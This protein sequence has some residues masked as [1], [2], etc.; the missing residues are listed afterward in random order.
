MIAGVR[1]PALSCQRLQAVQ[2]GV[3]AGAVPG[4]ALQALFHG[5]VVVVA[6]GGGVLP[7]NFPAAGGVEL[8]DGGMVARQAPFRDHALQHIGIVPQGIDN[9]VQIAVAG[10]KLPVPAGVAGPRR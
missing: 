6:N 9:G 8:V 7:G 3:V 4:A 5:L 10:A 1:F 2:A